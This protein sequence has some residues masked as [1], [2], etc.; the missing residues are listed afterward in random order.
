MTTRILF[1]LFIVS[2]FSACGGDTVTTPE[3]PA[4][5]RGLR[6]V[7]NLSK[8]RY[9]HAATLLQDG[10]VLIAGGL[11][12]P[13]T[14]REHPAP[15]VP[16]VLGQRPGR[17]ASA[18][19][20]DP[21]T[22]TSSPTG[23]MTVSRYSD[24]GILLPDGRVLFVPTFGHFPFEMYDFHSARFDFVTIL[25]PG[26]SIQT[27]SPL[28]NGKVFLTTTK[29]AGVLDPATGTIS[30]I[31]WMDHPRFGHTATVMKDGRVLIVGGKLVKGD[32]GLVG[33]NLI[34]DP[35]SEA[36]SEA[37]NLKFDRVHHKAVLLQDGRVLIVGGDVGDG[38]HV[39]TAEIYDPET[40]TF[41]PAGTSGMDPLAALLL[42]S[43]R[44][45]FIH[46]D[47]GSIALYNPD[48]QVFSPTG[49]SI[50]QW[51]SGATVTRLDDGRVVIAG[52][53]N[54]SDGG[55]SAVPESISDQIFVFTP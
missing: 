34:Y 36:F 4:L 44:V 35:S 9:W 19:I 33:R 54:Y 43:G 49:H 52:G 45:F 8:P 22:G 53:V 10:R 25:H 31:I 12:E 17:L 37:G 16:V 42:P 24:H 7:G 21:E 29:L 18:E 15:V 32:G 27:T 51:R 11:A 28:A 13:P 41:S 48:T 5:E 30:A 2:S 55:H 40:N 23:S 46:R 20:F 47:N 6:E 14:G 26:I 50:G 3:S 39:Q 1:A 38:P